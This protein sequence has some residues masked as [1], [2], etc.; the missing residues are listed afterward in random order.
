MQETDRDIRS[1]ARK[2]FARRGLE[3]TSTR[4]IAKAAGIAV[5]T[6][7]NYFPS[8]EALVFAYYEDNQEAYEALANTSASFDGK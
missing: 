6:L 8:K 2:L 3:G 7:F 4:Q 5:G 1:A